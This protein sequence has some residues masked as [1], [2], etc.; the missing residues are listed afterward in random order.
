MPD[1]GARPLDGPPE[2]AAKRQR[3]HETDVVS[4]VPN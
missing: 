2:S 4:G 3:I 1:T